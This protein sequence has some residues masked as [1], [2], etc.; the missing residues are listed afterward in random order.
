[1]ITSYTANLFLAVFICTIVNFIQPIIEKE[2]P[3]IRTSI[4]AIL[5]N[6]V[7]YDILAETIAGEILAGHQ[8]DELTIGERTFVFDCK[9]TSDSERI[10]TGVEFMGD[11]EQYTETKY[12]LKSIT[13]DGAYNQNGD[14]LQMDIDTGK[15]E[16]KISKL[17]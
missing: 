14:E 1:M 15:L 16:S 6:S 11:K 13:F 2:L 7:N 5:E 8:I 9:I 10:Y 4:H 17:L 3:A 12:T